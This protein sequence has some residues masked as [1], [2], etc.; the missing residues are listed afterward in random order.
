VI[1][2]AKYQ[3][4]KATSVL[5]FN[6]INTNL[7][8]D[9]MSQGSWTANTKNAAAERNLLGRIT[10]VLMELA[11]RLSQKRIPHNIPALCIKELTSFSFVKRSVRTSTG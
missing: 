2:I 8:T 9:P 10:V 11:P 6:H 1:T 5:G 3:T 4:V 7:L